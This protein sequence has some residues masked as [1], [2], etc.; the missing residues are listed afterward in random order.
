MV[1]IP[2]FKKWLSYTPNQLSTMFASAEIAQL[3]MLKLN[4]THPHPEKRA[5][6]FLAS[7]FAVKEAVYK[8]ISGLCADSLPAVK[9]FTF[10][11]IARFISIA[12]DHRWGSP[13]I[14]LDSVRFKEATQ[15]ALPALKT[16][17]S[18]SH[19]NDYAIAQVVVTSAVKE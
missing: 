12:P 4:T 15:V 8:A 10:R 18:L 13:H 6:Q 16:S 19:D 7:R 2:R 1:Y 3:E 17:V 11:S 14:Q 5:M 9:P